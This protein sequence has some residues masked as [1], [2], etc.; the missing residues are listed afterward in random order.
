MPFYAYECECGHAFEVMLK[1]SESGQHQ[2]CPKCKSVETRKVVSRTHVI[3]KGDGWTDKN[4]R[5]KKQMAAKN[6]RLSGKEN[7]RR[8]EAPTATLAP[9][10]DGERVASW[11]EAK[12]LAKSKGKNSSSYDGMVR[13]EIR[14]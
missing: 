13:K 7:E 14:A 2:D 6:R 8:Q 5:I 12:K 11:K 3:F 10:V 4:L 9:N 1:M